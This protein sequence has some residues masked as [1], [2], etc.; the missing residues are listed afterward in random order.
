LRGAEKALHWLSR[1]P[2]EVNRVGGEERLS[3]MTLLPV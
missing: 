1:P 2:G 3:E